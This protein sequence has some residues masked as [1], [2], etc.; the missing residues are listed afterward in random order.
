MFPLLV[1]VLAFARPATAAPHEIHPASSLDLSNHRGSIVVVH[2]W[3]TW[4]GPCLAEMPSLITF[5]RETYP[6][7]RKHGRGLTFVLISLDARREDLNA[8]MRARNQPFPVFF[9]PYGRWAERLEM[10]TVPGTVIIGAD[11]GVLERRVGATEWQGRRWLQTL[12][13]ML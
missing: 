9:D 13:G 11:G 6:R 1:F 7:L 5:Y 10:P 8:F 2:F 3:A 4:C 12:R